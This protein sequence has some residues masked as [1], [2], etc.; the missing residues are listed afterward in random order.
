MCEF[1]YVQCG[2]VPQASFPPKAEGYL[3]PVRG[4]RTYPDVLKPDQIVVVL[5]GDMAAL[6]TEEPGH[7]RILR[8]GNSFGKRGIVQA[9][10][11]DFRAIQPM[12]DVIAPDHDAT[13]I[14]AVIME[15]FLPGRGC[16]ENVERGSACLGI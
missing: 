7:H 16:P 12:L 4:E 14:E 11:K 6:A 3:L 10:F 15:E 2:C 9:V 13:L 1:E 8:S 5:Q